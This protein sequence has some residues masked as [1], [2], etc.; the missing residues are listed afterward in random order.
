MSSVNIWREREREREKGGGG[1][2]HCVL[3]PN[4]TD[5]ATLIPYTSLEECIVLARRCFNTK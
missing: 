1:E 3:V 4:F 2:K 5:L